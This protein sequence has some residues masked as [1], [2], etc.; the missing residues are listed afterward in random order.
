M[1]FWRGS[2]SSGGTYSE[3]FCSVGRGA[4]DF[5]KKK[6]D[7]LNNENPLNK[8]PIKLWQYKLETNYRYAL[9]NCPFF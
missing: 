6:S 5:F 2:L 4:V 8:K 7:F 1:I 9:V 3:V